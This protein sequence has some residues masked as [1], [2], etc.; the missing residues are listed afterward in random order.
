MPLY[1]PV[2]FVDHDSIYFPQ[3]RCRNDF[4]SRKFEAILPSKIIRAQFSKYLFRMNASS[5]VC[6]GREGNFFKRVNI[7]SGSRTSYRINVFKR[8]FRFWMLYIHHYRNL[9][10]FFSQC[11]MQC[12]MRQIHSQKMKA[13]KTEMT[14]FLRT[15]WEAS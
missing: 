1:L 3:W 12:P 7:W 10:V 9:Y 11:L 4:I 6:P 2:S 14:L 15:V 8:E 13:I 5:S